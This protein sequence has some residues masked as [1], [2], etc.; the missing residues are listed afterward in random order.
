MKKLVLYFTVDGNTEAVAEAIAKKVD[1]DIAR[2]V[3]V[4]RVRGFGFFNNL[5]LRMEVLRKKKPDIF[6]FK[7]DPRDYDLIYIGTPNWYNSYNP[8]YNT[9]FHVI[10][11]YDRKI[12]LFSTGETESTKAV[13]KLADKLHESVLL[14]KYHCVEP[15]WCDEDEET[16]KI[17][18]EAAAWGESISQ[19]AEK[20]LEEEEL[21]RRKTIYK[22]GGDMGRVE[23]RQM[24]QKKDKAAEADAGEAEAAAAVDAELPT[25]EA[26]NE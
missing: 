11:I 10:K 3:R 15:I 16:Q 26:G 8:V 19:K 4:K 25:D 20:M 9:L 6:P 24:N 13:D 7:Y 17:L 1:A 12:A 22:I 2:L 18:E 23:A 14:G 21:A 5:K